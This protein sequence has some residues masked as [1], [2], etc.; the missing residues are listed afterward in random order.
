[1]NKY[2]RNGGVVLQREWVSEE[3]SK[4]ES[5]CTSSWSHCSGDP[6]STKPLP[7]FGHTSKATQ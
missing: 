1:M 7:Q 3:G 4:R 5:E 2:E 6:S